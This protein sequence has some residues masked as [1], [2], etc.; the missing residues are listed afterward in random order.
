MSN[1]KPLK[2]TPD[3]LL[4]VITFS[5]A[6][7]LEDLTTTIPWK[8]KLIGQQIRGLFNYQEMLDMVKKDVWLFGPMAVAASW[9]S[10][11][12]DSMLRHVK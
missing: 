6:D 12:L 11:V 8:S 4:G 9:Q 10:A 3:E 7:N 1:D 5:P 2:I